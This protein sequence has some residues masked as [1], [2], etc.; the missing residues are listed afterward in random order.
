MT[1]LFALALPLAVVAAGCSKKAPADVNEMGAI[2]LERRVFADGQFAM[3]APGPVD[4]T[5]KD[6][7]KVTM[8]TKTFTVAGTT[9]D[10]LLGVRPNAGAGSKDDPKL[11]DILVA[12][13]LEVAQGKELARES[14]KLE[15]S[16][17]T[18]TLVEY[19]DPESGPTRFVVIVPS[20]RAFLS[21]RASKTGGAVDKKWLEQIVDSFEVLKADD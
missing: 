6:G 7:P 16:K 3:L 14:R 4:L 20:D 2:P 21:L 11:R 19:D 9:L 5:Q 1:W 10:I 18:A 13:E 17:L 12:T 8:Y 15:K